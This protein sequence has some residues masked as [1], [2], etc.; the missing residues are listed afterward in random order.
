M[1]AGSKAGFSSM[2]ASYHGREACLWSTG[3]QLTHRREGKSTGLGGRSK[4]KAH[5][6]PYFKK[7][8]FEM[9]SAPSPHFRA[10]L[11]IRQRRRPSSFLSWKTTAH[12]LA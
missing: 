4:K 12:A 1:G 5:F 3:G 10:W 9:F 8:N 7:G 2:P 6:Y 11:D